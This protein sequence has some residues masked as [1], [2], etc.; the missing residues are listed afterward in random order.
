MKPNK[1]Q[2]GSYSKSGLS[3]LKKYFGMFENQLIVCLLILGVAMLFKAINVP[4]TNKAVAE[5]KSVLNYNSNYENTKKGL[6]LVMSKIPSLKNDVVKVFSNKTEDV[7]DTVTQNVNRKMIRPISGDIVSAFG[8]KVD[9]NSR[10]EIKNDGIDISVTNDEPV[11][12]V[13]DGE[14]MIADNSNPDWGKVVVIRHDGDVRSVYAYLSEIDVK[15]GDKVLQG[16][17]IGRIGSDKNK[18]TSMHFEIWENGK[19]VDPES[20]INFN[21]VKSD[22]QNEN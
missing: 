14:V 18:S 7:K 22:V 20:K 16:Q 11:E 4:M 1:W 3:N 9:P 6:K 5:V 2:S 10:K 13:L 15:V 21:V 12:A 17:V 8:T 19:P